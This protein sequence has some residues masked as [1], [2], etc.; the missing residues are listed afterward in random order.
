MKVLYIDQDLKRIAGIRELLS[1][2]FNVEASFNGWEG[3]A[4]SMMYKPDIV[5][6]N[7]M[8]PIMDGA[9]VIRLIRTEEKLKDL[10]VLGFTEPRNEYVEEAALN[11]GCNQILSFPFDKKLIE[12]IQRYL[13]PPPDTKPAPQIAN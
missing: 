6:I 11:K 2:N 4:A 10:P 3:L 1:Q 5:L 13:P 12:V 9:E 7:L 8:A